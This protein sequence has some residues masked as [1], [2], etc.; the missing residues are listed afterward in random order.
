M[1]NRRFVKV[2]PAVFGSG[3]LAF[4][5]GPDVIESER[6][7]LSAASRLAEIA[8]RL[9]IGLVFK[10]SFDKANRTSIQSFRGPG[11]ERGLETLAKVREKTGLP[12]TSD[13]HLPEQAAVAGRI[14]D[15]IQIP[16]FLARQTD[17]VVAAGET[18]KPVNVKK[19]Q[20]AAPKDLIN[21]IEKIHSTG[22]TNILLTERGS[23]FGYNTLVVDMTSIPEMAKLGCPVIMDATH[24]VQRPGGL[25]TATG[26]HREHIPVLARAAVAAGCD[27]V[28]M[29]VH[30][31]PEKALCDGPSQYPLR[32]VE[33]LIKTLLH[34]HSAIREDGSR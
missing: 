5:A 26:G 4:I 12:I 25:G 29:E 9:N 8:D 19:P 15:L 30:P 3:K 32:K 1:K 13:I 28:F 10:S 34:I 17:I 33:N 24:S 11:L 7:V 22:N 2:G 16:A 27:G 21:V 20:F 23:C 18:G 6:L 31:N 14:L